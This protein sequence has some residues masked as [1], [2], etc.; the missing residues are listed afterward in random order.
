MRRNGMLWEKDTALAWFMPTKTATQRMTLDHSLL[1]L[2][3]SPRRRSIQGYSKP[4]SA[5]Q[6]RMTVN[7]TAYAM[8][9]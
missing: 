4:I 5:E 6:T 7:H 9:E 8:P 3:G 1:S 2:W